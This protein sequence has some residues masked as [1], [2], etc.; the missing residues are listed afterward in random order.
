MGLQAAN[1]LLASLLLRSLL[2]LRLRRRLGG[3]LLSVLALLG[4]LLWLELLSL[5][6][7]PLLLRAL[8]LPLRL[9]LCLL[10]CTLRSLSLRMLLCVRC[11][12]RLRRAL[13]WLLFP[14]WLLT[15]AIFGLLLLVVAALILR[16]N[17][18]R[19]EQ[20]EGQGGSQTAEYFEL[21]HKYLRLLS[22]VYLEGLAS[23]M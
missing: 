9:L 8:L 10:L 5:L 20:T 23:Y 18:T 7:R 13:L 15:P 17:H 6:S 3:L 14:L 21:S 12:L 11:L 22:W 2:R 16:C 19:R 1:M 4:R